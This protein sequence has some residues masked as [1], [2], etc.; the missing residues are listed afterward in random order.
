MVVEG[1]PEM[2]RVVLTAGYK[3]VWY[4]PMNESMHLMMECMCNVAHQQVSGSQEFIL[5]YQQKSYTASPWGTVSAGNCIGYT[6]TTY[7]HASTYQ[8]SKNTP[9]T[10]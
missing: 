3:T 1:I 9:V 7:V 10:D 5:G 2:N 8:F 6:R 4:A